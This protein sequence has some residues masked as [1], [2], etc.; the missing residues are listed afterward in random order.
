MS[1]LYRLLLSS[2]AAH[3]IENIRYPVPCREIHS[4]RHRQVKYTLERS[5]RAGCTA[6]VNAV[7]CKLAYARIIIR[8]CVKL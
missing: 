6:A 5:H 2:A 8:Y 1:A 3:R 7:N 4:T